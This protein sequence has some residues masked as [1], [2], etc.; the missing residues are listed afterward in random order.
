MHTY[1][2]NEYMMRIREWWWLFLYYIVII[3]TITYAARILQL[4]IYMDVF[5]I[6][7]VISLIIIIFRNLL[8]YNLRAGILTDEKSI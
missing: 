8:V 1:E 7:I 3:K 4:Y 2:N 6:N 5:Y